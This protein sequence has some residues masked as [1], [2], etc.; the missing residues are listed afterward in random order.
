[1]LLECNPNLKKLS[2]HDVNLADHQKEVLLLLQDPMLQGTA[3]SWAHVPRK[4]LQVAVFDW[5]VDGWE[6]VFGCATLNKKSGVS[7]IDL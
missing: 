1:M 6:L 3:N 4:V 2:F 5:P 7:G